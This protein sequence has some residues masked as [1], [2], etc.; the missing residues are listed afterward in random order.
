MKFRN[1]QSCSGCLHI[2]WMILGLIGMVYLLVG[3]TLHIVSIVI[4]DF[5]DFME[6]L[7]EDVNEFDRVFAEYT[8]DFND[9]LKPCLFGDGN[10]Q[11]ALPINDAFSDIDEYNEDMNIAANLGQL[12]GSLSV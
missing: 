4:M 8:E 11:S 10:M 5:C 9:M 3:P 12:E 1:N 7:F 2:F 6:P